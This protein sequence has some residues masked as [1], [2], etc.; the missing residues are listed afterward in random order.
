[1]RFR[2][3]QLDTEPLCAAAGSEPGRTRRDPWP[4]GWL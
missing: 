3:E 2:E 1:V 4:R